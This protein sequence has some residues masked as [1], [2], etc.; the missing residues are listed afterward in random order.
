MNNTRWDRI[1]FKWKMFKWDNGLDAFDPLF[2]G[3]LRA[4]MLRWYLA[5]HIAMH[6]INLVLLVFLVQSPLGVSFALGILYAILSEDV[7]KR[8]HKLLKAKLKEGLPEDELVQS[9]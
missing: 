2:E 5:A 4:S 6:A 8:V 7:Y 3:T 9:L 1:R